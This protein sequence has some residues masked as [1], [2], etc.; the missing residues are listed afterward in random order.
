MGI[1]EITITNTH[2]HLTHYLLLNHLND[3]PE[4]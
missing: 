1:L 3:A 4:P 2:T